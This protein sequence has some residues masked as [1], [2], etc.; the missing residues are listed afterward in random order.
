MQYNMLTHT[1]THTHAHTHTHTRT[2]THPNVSLCCAVIGQSPWD[3]RRASWS[4]IGRGPSLQQRR[5]QSSERDSLMSE[6]AGSEWSN[7]SWGWSRED[8]FD[9]LDQSEYLTVPMLR[10]PDCNGKTFHLPDA[11]T[12]RY[13]SDHDEEEEEDA[14]ESVCL[15]VKLFL[16]PYKPQWCRDHEDWALYLFSPC[17]RFRQWC[18]RVITHKMFDHIILLFI[19]LNCITIAL[20]RPDIQAHST[21]RVFLSVSNHIFTVIFIAEM[22]VKVVAQ[23]LYSGDAVYLKSSWN[24][25]DGMLVFVSLLDILVSVASAGGNRI[26]G[27]LRVLRLLRT[28]RPLRV[29]SRAPGLKLVVETLITSLRPIGN[30]VLICCGFFI[31]FGILGVQLFKGKFFHCEGVDVRN[32]TNRSD[33]LRAGHRW[34]RRKYNFDNLGQALM[35]LFVLSS[36]DG[37][38]SIMYDGL[39]AV[40]VDQQ[41]V[42]NHNPWMLLFFISFL[43]IVSFFVLNMF[44]GVVV[45]NFHKCRQD[46]EEEEAKAREEKRAKRAEKRRR[47]AQERP[48]Y[49]DYSPVRLTIH[50][51]CTSHYLDLFITVIIATNVLTMSMEHYNQ[52]QYLEEGLKYCNYIF[53]LVF[54]VETVLKLIAFGLRRFFRERWNQLDL[55]I[56]LL[57]VMGITLEEI[58]LNASLP[59]NPTIIRI[60]RVLRIA[61]V[62]KLLKMATGMRAL[63][64]TVVQA[65]P[66]VGN[67][68]LLFM[69]LFFIYAALGVELF[70]KL[71]CSEENPCEG[72]SRHATFQNFGMAFLTLFRVS[73]GDNWNGIMKDTLRECRPEDRSCLTYLPLVSPVYFV[74][75]VLT[76]QFVLVNVVVAVLMKHL[77]ESNKEAQEEAEEEAK[78]EEARQEEARQQEARQEEARQE[79]IC[80]FSNAAVGGV[81]SSGQVVEEK[82]CRGSL[83]TVGR[84]SLS[85]MMSLPSD[86]YMLRPLQ[87]LGHTRYP[88]I[89]HD[90][91]KGCGFS[92]SVYSMGSSGAGSLLQVPGALP[93]GSHASLSS[94]G[95]SC[96]PTVRLSPSHSVDRHSLSMARHTPRRPGHVDSRRASYKH[97]PSHS[98]DTHSYRLSPA[99]SID[100]DS[101]RYLDRRASYK[102]SP[103]HSMDSRHTPYIH[104]PSHSMDSRHTPY[105]HS[106][107]HSM[108]SRHTP[109]MD[110]H[111]PYIHS[112][113]HSMDSRQTPYIHS[114]S[115]S[116]DSRHTPY[117]S[118]P[119][120][121]MDRQ[122]SYRVSPS[123]SMDRQGSYRLS[124]SHS[125]DRQPGPSSSLSVRRQLRRQEAVRCDSV[126]L[127]CSSTDDLRGGSVDGTHLT[128]PSMHLSPLPSLPPGGNTH[129]DVRHPSSPSRSPRGRTSSA[130]T[131]RHTHTVHTLR[132]THSQR[133][134]STRGHSRSHSDSDS[135]RP[136]S[137]Q[138]S[139]PQTTDDRQTLQ[140]P[141]IPQ[142]PSPSSRPISLCSGG[143]SLSLS[144]PCTP[145]TPSPNLT[146]STPSPPQS[147]QTSFDPNQSPSS[148]PGPFPPTLGSSPSRLPT[149]F[150]DETDDE[151]CHI[152]HQASSPPHTP[153]HTHHTSS[154]P[155]TPKHT[156][157]T[158]CLPHT[159]EHTHHTPR[160]PHTP[161]HTHHTP[162]PP[163]TPRSPHPYLSLHACLSFEED[164]RSRYLSSQSASPVREWTRKQRMSPPCIS[165]A[166]PVEAQVST[167]TQS[168]DNSMHLRRRTLSVDSASQR[169]SLDIDPAETRLSVPFLQLDSSFISITVDSDQSGCSLLTDSDSTV[170]GEGEG[171]EGGGARNSQS[172]LGL[173]PNPL[174][175]RSLVRMLSTREGEGE[176]TQ[177]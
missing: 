115:H 127:T 166:P 105:I 174:R 140:R 43:L 14:E 12:L 117:I 159:P 121:S 114:P 35:S 146:I 7:P 73:T 91:Y 138:I 6:G 52:P 176:E 1:H 25:L 162:R 119:S 120:H 22:T 49:A 112:P 148:S 124:P 98:M 111:T 59:I 4:S 90:T 58:D 107:S 95:S 150:L 28:L 132:H 129:L 65:L 71:E 9:V 24:V 64:D 106:P 78:E 61:R 34:T 27:I 39:D 110:R 144:S 123:H 56:V 156:H 173:V 161:E 66:Q 164:H 54:V 141:E 72:L 3:S 116:M 46:Q 62:L 126:D 151:I 145:S 82:R 149:S 84:P 86:S 142:T 158:S 147:P 41:P 157:H 88:P 170:E 155:H 108:D 75:F 60:M 2:H 85:R 76:A 50:T 68:G 79:A 70:G 8:S 109:R 31:V 87:P 20:E 102:H 135:Q 103:S 33:C 133:I 81:E 47:K 30:I 152:T 130:H 136:P 74:T 80:P 23:G 154:P 53:T 19:F 137:P 55:A 175:R 100:R 139:T 99:Q 18:Q 51:L 153:K 113:S 38:V 36:K 177:P 11:G 118:S 57:S 13:Y 171:R 122:G 93:S 17:N 42:R 69:L 63:L 15:R 26:L 40:G 128:V 32:V 104:S 67:L 45:E 143:P 48:Y 172:L 160:P 97:S 16:Q 5:S 94:R 168:T 167:V 165:V 77:D 101:S 10:P 96:R 21:E 134:I 29:I 92:G 125:M 169:D 83:L 44:V 37:W 131:L 163:H 89:G